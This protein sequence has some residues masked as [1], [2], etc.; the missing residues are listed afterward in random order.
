MYYSA[1]CLEK[2]VGARPTWNDGFRRL[3]G[4]SQRHRLRAAIEFDLAILD[5]DV[6]P[7][8]NLPP[9]SFRGRVS[10]AIEYRDHL[11]NTTSAFRG[12]PMFRPPRM[13]NVILIGS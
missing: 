7:G 9:A 4:H 3:L 6:W 5:E 8:D 2:S 13:N 12:S 11:E 10:L 1:R